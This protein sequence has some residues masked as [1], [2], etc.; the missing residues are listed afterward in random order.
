MRNL[1]AAALG[2]V[3]ALGLGLSGM[4]DPNNV[5]GFLDLTGDWNPA[6]LFVMATAVPIYAAAWFSGQR[7][8]GAL[9]PRPFPAVRHDVDPGMLLGSA[10]FGIGWG[11]AGI[12]PGPA[13]TILAGATPES[14][15]FLA[16]VILGMSLFRLM[17]R[18]S[19][20]P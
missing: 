10:L 2:V 8:G 3:F 1:I 5:L 19:S 4:T 9:E 17:A 11:L 13:V 15:W 16:C 6:L 12:C 20:T 14:A 7:R 18:E